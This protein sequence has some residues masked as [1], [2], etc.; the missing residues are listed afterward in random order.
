MRE[1]VSESSLIYHSLFIVAE[2]YQVILCV[3]ALIQ[4]N[5]AQLIGLILFGLLVIGYAGIQ[6]KQHMI[7]EMAVCGMDMMTWNPPMDS[8][9]GMTMDDMMNAM[10]Y[11]HD[12]MVPVEYTIIVLIPVFFAGLIFLA[13]RLRKRFAWDNYRN[14]S[15]DIKVRQALVMIGILLTCLKLDFFFIFSFAAQL[16]VSSKIG[17]D[18]TTNECIVDFV[19]GALGLSFTLWAVYREN[20]YGMGVSI[21]GGLTAMGYF[22]FSL[23]RIAKPRS[24]DNDPYQNTR[25]FLIF[26]T[27]ISI[28][29]MLCTLVSLCISFKNVYNDIRTI[30]DSNQKKIAK[31]KT[32]SID[33]ASMEPYHSGDGMVQHKSSKT[34][35]GDEE[36]EHNST[37]NRDEI[38]MWTIE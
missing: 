29:L 35:L 32:E 6:L 21:L 7:L 17:Y 34:Q 22:L 36:S 4:R 26:T 8:R 14:F 16:I 9:W 19:L 28:F 20:L 25:P 38:N 12:I 18:S 1:G 37:R 31:E 24:M 3:D 10:A 33:Q 13:W 2:V 23:Y 27:V 15:A 11:Y 5:T 30:S